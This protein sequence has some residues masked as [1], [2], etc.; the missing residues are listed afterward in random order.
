M[1]ENT[2]KAIL[3]ELIDENP[4]AVRA[5]LKILGVEFTEKVPTLA[6]TCEDR[7]L[8]LVNL[9]FVRK[10]CR[11][12]AQVKALICHEFLHV[13]LRHTEKRGPASNAEHL[14]FDAVIN[15]IIHR[16]EGPAYSSMMS[17]YYAKETGLMRL[18]RPMTEAESR[19][20]KSLSYRGCPAW[21]RAWLKLYE[22]AL[23]ADD[24]ME[25]AS[26]LD[27]TSGGGIIIGR[28][29]G[30]H[31]DHPVSGALAE[32]LNKSLKAMN[33]SGIWRSPRG[34]GVGSYAYDALFSAEDEATQ[35]WQRATLAVFK[36]HVMPDPRSRATG[37]AESTYTMPV[38]SQGD[39][40]AFLRSQWDPF[41][42]EAS[43]NFTAP[44]KLGTTQV[45]LDV[46][47]SMEA[48]M[49]I[50]IALLNRLRRHIKTPFWA[51]SNEVSPAVIE[52]GQLKTRT[53]GG[54]SMACVLKHL[55]KT[56]PEAAVVITDGYIETLPA[57]LLSKASATRLHAVVSRD[58]SPNLLAKA[59]IPYTQL[60]RRPS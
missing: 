12:Q 7:P 57:E 41:I 6:V 2:F 54:T 22:G 55:A 1:N 43:W 49:P 29:L 60:D 13:L 50:L 35:R 44:R 8:L 36:K 27:Q 53:T 39:R 14:A 4:F 51:F 33:G 34:R 45:Y 21:V 15:A 28:L 58:G 19:G 20:P 40:R 38:L 18:L 46:S 56:R 25:M 24:I 59:G 48:E 3:R 32:A 9:S 30:D 11:T 23:V 37:K 47:G 5:A 17:E 42:P 26:N 16:T 52:G 31:S 10:H